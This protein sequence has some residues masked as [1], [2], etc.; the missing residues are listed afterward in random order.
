MTTTDRKPA[1]W[2]YGGR[3]A[4]KEATDARRVWVKSGPTKNANDAEGALLLVSNN[5]HA[6]RED[7]SFM[8]R[9][10]RAIR[11]GKFKNRW[12]AELARRAKASREGW[13]GLSNA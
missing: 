9:T 4:L 6:R 2:R 8:R 10:R 3:R 7:A 12:E 5:R 1:H 11:R 13:P